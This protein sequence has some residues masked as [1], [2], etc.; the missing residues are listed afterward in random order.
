M[1][2]IY[3]T[4]TKCLLSQYEQKWS[5]CDSDLPLKCFFGLCQPLESSFIKKSGQKFSVILLTKRQTNWSENT[6]SLVEVK[7]TNSAVCFPSVKIWVN[8]WWNEANDR[9]QLR[10]INLDSCFFSPF[11]YKACSSSFTQ[12]SLP[13]SL[14]SFKSLFAFVSQSI[15]QPT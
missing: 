1:Y 7:S 3:F 10:F 12:V 13:L 8:S 9:K 2:N 4:R 11:L 14:K 15:N 6:I 5:R